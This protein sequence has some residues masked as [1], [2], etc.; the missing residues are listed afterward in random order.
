MR[1]ILYYKTKGQKPG[2]GVFEP[3]PRRRIR[4]NP[5]Q[6]LETGSAFQAITE[7]LAVVGKRLHPTKGFRKLNVRNDRVVEVIMQV[8]AGIKGWDLLSIRQFLLEGHN[9]RVVR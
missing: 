5:G 1:D 4:V 8:K 6:D 9:A 2:K 3:K 7:Q